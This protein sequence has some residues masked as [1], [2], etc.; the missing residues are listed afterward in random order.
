M[1]SD[2]PGA[3]DDQP[4]VAIDDLSDLRLALLGS[5][6]S[7]AKRSSESPAPPRESRSTCAHRSSTAHPAVA[8]RLKTSV[9]QNPDSARNS[10]TALAPVRVTPA[11]SSS[12]KRSI[13]LLVFA[14]PLR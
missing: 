7:S 2:Q 8:K 11:I 6:R 4:P 9:F 10:L 5:P 3:A 13:A 12:Q 14:D 1:L